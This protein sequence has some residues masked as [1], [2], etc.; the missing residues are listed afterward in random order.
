MDLCRE[1]MLFLC[2][3]KGFYRFCLDIPQIDP[4]LAP[5]IWVL[6]AR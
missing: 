4:I 1:D 3:H 5:S 6:I 2:N